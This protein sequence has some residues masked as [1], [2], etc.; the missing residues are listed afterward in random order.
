MA[1]QGNALRAGV[2]IVA[3]AVVSLALV[4]VVSG[5][6]RFAAKTEYVGV[7]RIEDDLQ[8]V[9]AGDEVR[10]G[11]LRVGTVKRVDVDVQKDPAEVRVTFAIPARYQ[12]R[13][14]ATMSV[15]GLIGSAWLNIDAL[16]TGGV[17]PPGGALLGGPSALTR[18]GLMAPK[19]EQALTDVR[20]R[21]LPLI[22]QTIQ[23]YRQLAVD[24]REKSLPQVAAAADHARQLLE[25]LRGQIKP[26]LDRYYAVA[27]SA[28]TAMDNI[29]ALVGPSGGPTNTD[30]QQT[31]SN[32]NKATATLRD[33][34]PE[35][36][37]RVRTALDQANERLS[38]LQDVADDL[39]VTMANA[40]DLSAEL[41]SVLID[42]RAKIDRTLTSVEESARNARMF[43]AEIL[44]RPSRLLW[45][46]D[47]QT[48][49][50]LQVY[51]SAREFATGAQELNDA[52]SAL[53]N[54]LR[55]PR[56]SADEFQR[57][58]QQLDES[59]RRFS[60]VEDKLYRAVRP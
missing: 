25:E 54:A 45:R 28:R 8:G 36:T 35:I 55:D 44:R 42:N 51:H 7:F 2:F 60:D 4:I 41:R 14:G 24:A 49:M 19:I 33:E 46:D 53:R 16:G 21:T 12:L 50:N 31:L 32:L 52:V 23:D 3:A 6:E 34:L 18:L 38:K 39:K 17:L 27:D 40:K 57:R 58:L 9:R 29:G 30:F 47:P 48:Q 1:G 20:T 59:F 56:L 11:G 26:V 43:T 10:L 5:P 22:E 15:G 13:Q 37:A